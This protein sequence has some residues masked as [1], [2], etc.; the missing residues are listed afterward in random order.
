MKQVILPSIIIKF[1][2]LLND[3]VTEEND[4]AHA[5]PKRKLGFTQYRSSLRSE[6][7]AKRYQRNFYPSQTKCLQVSGG[8]YIMEINDTHTD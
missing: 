2:C 7:L 4:T 5:L 6:P 8:A 3:R 1:T